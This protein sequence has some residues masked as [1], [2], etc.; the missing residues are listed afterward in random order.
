MSETPEDPQNTRTV[1]NPGDI[2]RRNREQLDLSL[3]I[4]SLQLNL[5]E[6]I[7][8]HIERGDFSKLPGLTFA[9]GYVRSYAKLLALDPVPLVEVFDRYTGTRATEARKIH[10]VDY[11][12]QSHKLSMG[13]LRMS[14]FLVFMVLLS[15]GL[16]WWQDQQQ[17]VLPPSF[18]EEPA[19]VAIDSADGTTQIHPLDEPLTV[20]EPVV[21][22]SHEPEKNLASSSDAQTAAPQEMPPAVNPPSTPV[23][24]EVS[25][26]TA[27]PQVQPNTLKLK[28]TADCW[29]QVQ[30][31]AGK[32]LL[33]TILHAG[34][35]RVLQGEPPLSLRVGYVPGLEVTYNNESV[36]LAPYAKGQT[37]RLKLGQE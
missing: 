27:V 24:E 18:T 2:L 9:R 26:V 19:T 29:V 20:N 35:E 1:V 10:S 16:Y 21:P 33:I 28:A 8:G 7:L 6:E 30:D 3:S 23:E 5:S 37:A 25:E 22:D 15:G 17:D 34:D 31:S 11:A 12:R 4:V 36:D 14:A 32:T 13:S